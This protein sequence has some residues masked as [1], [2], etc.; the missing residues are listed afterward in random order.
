MNFPSPIDTAVWSPCSRFIAISWSRLLATIEIL[1][2]VTLG[3]LT[4]L[5]Y[6]QGGLLATRWLVFSPDARMLTWFGAIPGRF[7]SWDLQT[8]GLVSAILPEQPMRSIDCLSVTYS[9]C[10]T[11]F[12]VLLRGDPGFTISTYNVLSG[13]HLYSHSAQGLPLNDIWTHGE[14]LR[15]AAMKSGSISTWETGFYST[16]TLTEVESL[17]IPGDFDSSRGF[18]FHPTPSRLAFIAGGR[19]KIWDAEDSKF[20]LDSA[21]VELPRQMSFSLDGSFFACGTNGP[22]SYLWKASPTGYTLHRKLMSNTEA[23]KPLISPNSESIIAFGDLVVQLWRTTDSTTSLSAVSTLA[24]KRSEKIF[25]LGFSPDE[26]LA[27]VTR[28]EGETVTVLDLKSG[29]PR[30]IIDTGMKVYALGVGGTTIV[31]V[32][33]GKIVTWSLPAEEHVPDLRVNINDSVLTTTFKHPPFATSVPIPPTSVSPDLR[34]IA[35]VE[36]RAPVTSYLHLYDVPTGQR[37]GYVAIKLGI[38]PWFTLDGREVWCVT[39]KDKVDR[40]KIVEGSESNVTKLEYLGTTV[41][42]PDGFPWQSSRGYEVT[43]GGWIVSYTG[44]RLLWLPPHWRSYGWDKMWSRR[45]LA[46]LGCE[47]LEPVILELEE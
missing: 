6:P 39:S 36:D 32:G 37:L 29:I 41:H 12:A 30:L 17:P 34:R 44:K 46:L 27:M 21:D 24:S 15:F 1:D 2:A 43:N 16:H 26:T 28:M 3:R 8:G 5:D 47:L 31:V 40:W 14:C 11:I 42:P 20:V 25:I 38:I 23:F 35:I 7:I 18:R 33:E 9:S 10:G 22:E 13:T 4:T 45:F 19:V